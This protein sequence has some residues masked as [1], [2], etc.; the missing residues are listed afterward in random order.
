MGCRLLPWTTPV[1]QADVILTLVDRA[2]KP[3]S[4]PIAT[5]GT[6]WWVFIVM[7]LGVAIV[8]VGP[9]LIHGFGGTRRAHYRFPKVLEYSRFEASLSN[10]S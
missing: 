7:S 5:L 8:E 10:N 2:D 9:C 4:N 6:I 1:S 3:I